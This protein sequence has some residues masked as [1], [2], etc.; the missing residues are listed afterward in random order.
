M[1]S[2]TRTIARDIKRKE[3]K[4]DIYNRYGIPYDQETGK[5]L[6]RVYGWIN[7][8]LI[9][10]ND[11][12]GP[13]AWHFSM[14]HGNDTW[15]LN[16]AL[17]TVE[18]VI[19]KSKNPAN[20]GKK[21]TVVVVDNDNPV[22]VDVQGTCACHCKGCYVDAGNYQYK[23]VLSS[24]A[25][26]TLIARNDLDYLERAIK[27]QIIADHIELL[28]IHAAGDFFSI[29]YVN[30]WQNIVAAF[31]GVL[32]WTYT[33]VKEFESAFD[34]FDNANIVHSV[35]DG[36]GF[37]FGH[38]DYIIKV[39]KYLISKGYRV[40][41]C[42]CGI[43][44]AAKI[45]PIHCTECQCCAH[46]DYVLFIE[47]STEYKAEKDPLFPELVKIILAQEIQPKSGIHTV[48]A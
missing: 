12:I 31:P 19:K 23:T 10:G 20:I 11:K 34:Q 36:Y 4:A 39:Y 18:T 48:A 46:C 22:F 32:F 14:L 15:H 21:K 37:N 26:K 16:I 3:T 30:T 9:N 41:V 33:K 27:A 5:I 45:K 24:L 43:E 1:S 13:G 47:H 40:H 35:I 42:F 29:E 44:N 28:R 38:C 7:P 2:K 6:H 8:L 25:I 17:K